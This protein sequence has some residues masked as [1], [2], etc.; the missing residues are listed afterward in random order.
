LNLQHQS[1]KASYHLLIVRGEGSEFLFFRN[2]ATYSLPTVSAYL[3]K[4]IAPQL[5]SQIKRKWKISACCLFERRTFGLGSNSSAQHLAVLEWLGQS[6]ER[7]DE[8]AWQSLRANM[9]CGLSGTVGRQTKDAL[10]E[11]D[12]YRNRSKWG[13]FARPGWLPELLRWTE[14]LLNA[15]TTL[16]FRQ[17]TVGPGSCLIQMSAGD[18]RVW[19]KAPGPFCPQELPITVSLSKLFPEYLPEILA[20]H[21]GWSGWLAREISAPT[22]DQC[23]H[24]SAW[25]FAAANLAKLQMESMGRSAE[26]L[27]ASCR[28]LRLTKLIELISPFVSCMAELVSRTQ[29]PSPEGFLSPSEFAWLATHLEEA[30]RSL[31]ARNLPDTLGNVDFNP[32][33]ILISKSSCHFLDWAEACVSSPLITFHFL[34]EHAKHAFPNDPTALSLLADSY[35]RQ[36]CA[37]CSPTEL[38][39]MLTWS[40]LVAIFAYGV[41]SDA[42]SSPEKLQDR[43]LCDYYC[44]LVRRMHRVAASSRERHPQYKYTNLDREGGACP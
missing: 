1:A 44:N 35:G 18:S 32:G 26:L 24:L 10:H 6:G 29:R 42:W 31:A 15:K 9:P 25:Q 20:V 8:S 7:L 22:L 30:C 19:F 3:D 14:G 5:L 41:A 38:E 37:L 27:N 12:L 36:W 34:I 16:E 33:N 43:A 23:H 40:S 4:R 39:E 17:L 13:P 2:G 21:T 11:L 28:D